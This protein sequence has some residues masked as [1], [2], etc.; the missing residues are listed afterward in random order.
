LEHSSLFQAI[1]AQQEAF[2]SIPLFVL[3]KDAKMIEKFLML[4]PL[5]PSS[6][7]WIL[8]KVSTLLLINKT[9]TTTMIG[10]KV[11]QEKD[12]S[13]ELMIKKEQDKVAMLL[14]ILLKS[15]IGIILLLTPRELITHI[16]IL[17]HPV[18]AFLPSSTT[19][20]SSL[21]SDNMTIKLIH[22]LFILLLDLE[23][24]QILTRLQNARYIHQSHDYLFILPEGKFYI[25]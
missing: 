15:N 4:L 3:E 14:S 7:Q 22:L 5:L 13:G 1:L 12:G 17:D 25:L 2:V 19:S 23:M 21:L 11:Q 20:V 16:P 8:D 18:I 10:E 9:K 6:S 24:A